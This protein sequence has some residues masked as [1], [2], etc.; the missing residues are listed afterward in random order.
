MISYLSQGG[1]SMDYTDDVSPHERK[2]IL[3]NL[4]KIKEI[5]RESTSSPQ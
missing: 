3:K 2:L 1:I 4:M 5:E